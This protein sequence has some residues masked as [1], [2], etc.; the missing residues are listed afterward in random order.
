MQMLHSR[1]IDSID[2]ATLIECTGRE[3]LFRTE[4]GFALYLIDGCPIGAALERVA[5]LEAREALLWLNENEPGPW[6]GVGIGGE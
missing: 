2:A 4:A 6:L 3:I 5:F 1:T